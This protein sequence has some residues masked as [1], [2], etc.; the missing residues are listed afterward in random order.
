MIA[1]ALSLAASTPLFASIHGSIEGDQLVWTSVVVVANANGH[2]EQRTERH[3]QRRDAPLVPPLVAALTRLTVDDGLTLALSAETQAA[4]GLEKR[5]GYQAAAGVS[6]RDRRRLDARFGEV[7]PQRNPLY[8]AA[9]SVD[10][11]PDRVL[12]GRV[13]DASSMRRTAAVGALAA[14]VVSVLGLLALVRF[15]ARRAALERAEAILDGELADQ[16]ASLNTQRR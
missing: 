13:L 2:Q 5:I 8:L 7:G 6:K 15:L 11:L 12:G 10:V 1:L 9:S 14:A 4:L 16:F 3:S